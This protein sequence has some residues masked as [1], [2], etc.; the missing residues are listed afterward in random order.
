MA[1]SV[2]EYEIHNRDPSRFEGDF[3]THVWCLTRWSRQPDTEQGERESR[4]PLASNSLLLSSLSA[5]TDPHTHKL[6]LII[7]CAERAFSDLNKPALGFLCTLCSQLLFVF[8]K[9]SELCSCF[10]KKRRSSC[11]FLRPTVHTVPTLT[12]TAQ[13]HMAFPVWKALISGVDESG[14]RLLALFLAW[15]LSWMESLQGYSAW[16]E[17]QNKLHKEEKRGRTITTS[18]RWVEKR[19]DGSHIQIKICICVWNIFHV[20]QM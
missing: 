6:T 7:T 3:N 16:K 19:T 4:W 10:N 1:H 11:R 12:H 5:R 8:M 15:G 9:K 17:L 18:D 20:Y 2:H 14:R 13:W